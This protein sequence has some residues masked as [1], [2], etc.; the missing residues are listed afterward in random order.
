MPIHYYNIDIRITIAERVQ[1]YVAKSIKIESTIE[2]FA[3]IA[4]IELPRNS[5]MQ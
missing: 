5:K 3:D 1:F 4:T 2:K